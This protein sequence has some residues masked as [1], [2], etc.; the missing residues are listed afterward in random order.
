MAAPGLGCNMWALFPCLGIELGAP[1]L[2]AWSLSHW[3]TREVHYG[4]FYVFSRLVKGFPGGTSGKEP[5]CQCR[6]RKRCRFDPWVGKIPWRRKGHPIPVVFPGK[7]HGQRN[8]VGYSPQGCNESDATEVTWQACTH[9]LVTFLKPGEVAT[10]RGFL[11]VLA[12]HSTLITQAVCSR[13]SIRGL[14]GSF[15]CCRLTMWVIWWSGW[16]QPS[17]LSGSVLCGCFWLLVKGFW[18]GGSWLQKPRVSP[19]SAGSLVGEVR[20]QKTLGLLP[21]P[22]PHPPLLGEARSWS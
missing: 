21:P 14:H 20:I 8:L 10:V 3:T 9:R 17:W 1:A 7:S 22:H 4:Y 12:V 5:T 15:C 19:T 11:C 13:D 16:P 18:S 6:R 2:G